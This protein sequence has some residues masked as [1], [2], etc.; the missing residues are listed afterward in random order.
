M[1]KKQW[2]LLIIILIIAIFLRFFQLGKTPQGFYLDE[3]ALGYNAY[4]LM[5]TG[6]DEF[7]KSW[8]IL[9]RS[10]GDFKAPVY[11]YLLIPIYKIFGMNVWTTRSLSATMGVI[12][13]WFCFWLIKNL[14]KKTN[15]ALISILLL[16]ISPWHLIF[17]RTSYETNVA[18]TFFIIALWSFYKF[19]QNRKYLILAAIMAALSFLTYHS[20]R[21]IVPL[22][23]LVLFIKENKNIFDKKNIKTIIIA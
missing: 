15:L 16:S 9:F 11:T 17:S 5:E 22:V 6:K 21:V 19:K 2:L 8:P 10:F 18:F 1:T 7:G 20:E 13:I 3:A 12:G 23:F 14:S 4:S